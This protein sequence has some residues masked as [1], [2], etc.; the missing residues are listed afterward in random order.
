MRLYLFRHGPAGIKKEWKGSDAQ[1]PLT[2]LG[3]EVTR[4]VAERLAAVGIDPDAIITSPYVRASQTAALLAAALG[5][6]E[7]LDDDLLSPGFSA[8]DLAKLI[9]RHPDAPELVLVGHDPDFSALI[10][11]LTGARVKLRKGGIARIDLKHPSSLEGILIWLAPPR[12][13]R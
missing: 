7:P 11:E 3:V 2:D 13:V 5:G 10:R 9:E 4:R 8:Q 1:R 6:P 12:L